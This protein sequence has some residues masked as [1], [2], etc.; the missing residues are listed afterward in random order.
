MLHRIQRFHRYLHN[1][2]SHLYRVKSR[3]ERSPFV[4][5]SISIVCMNSRIG[6]L[7]RRH[8]PLLSAVICFVLTALAPTPAP[9]YA[10]AISSNP[11][12]VGDVRWNRDYQR[13]LN[14]SRQT[15]KPLFLLFQ[16]V[17]G[18]IGCQNFGQQV[19]THSLLVEAIEDEFIP[20][21]VY[22]NRSNGMDKEVLERFDE[23]SWNYQVIRFVDADQADV[24]PRRDRIWDI[25]GVAAR[26]IEALEAVGRTVPRYLRAVAVEYDRD[27][28]ETAVFEMACFWTG[29]YSLGGIDGVVSTEAGWYGGRE[30]TLVAYNRR[31][32]SLERLVK[33]A[34][35]RNCAE[36]VY[37]DPEILLEAGNL[38]VKPFVRSRYRR[39]Q[40]SDQKKQINEWLAEHSDLNL[41][42]MQ[43]TKLN[44]L[45]PGNR[46]AA[47]SW[48]SPRQLAELDR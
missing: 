1:E 39:A 41:T 18:C 4:P 10:A 17:P 40:P 35:A 16:E 30:V 7:V 26:M 3:P 28:R 8:K 13:A 33:T 36:A 32:L 23:P 5:V 31:Q 19:L 37:V 42:P 43:S 46:E 2:I 44:A 24:I 47:Y 38:A 20:V 21:L 22:N 11:I 6:H 25:G 15:G 14:K 29:E 27:N 34:A 48:L 9:L 45:M 12:E